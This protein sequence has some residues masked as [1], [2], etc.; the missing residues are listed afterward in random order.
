MRAG[1]FTAVLLLATT[2]LPAAAADAPP[3]VPAPAPASS[4]GSSVDPSWYG[5]QTLIADAVDLGVLLI[6]LRSADSSTG[7]AAA[8]LGAVG[9]IAP[10]PLI[11]SRTG[12]VRGR[13]SASDFAWGC[14]CCS[15]G[16][17]CLPDRDRAG[18]RRRLRRARSI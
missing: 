6:A 17:G 3:Q 2:P 7:S 12:R 1:T 10:A 13:R 14:P 5:W 9:F 16:W 18:M 4:P 11:I 8:S 15:A